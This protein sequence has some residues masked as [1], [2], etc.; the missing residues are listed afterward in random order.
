M[1][2][3]FRDLARQV[4]RSSS[5][6]V[7]APRERHHALETLEALNPRQTRELACAVSVLWDEFVSQIGGPAGW[8]A[9]TQ[10]E[11]NQYLGSLKKATQRVRLAGG[12]EKLHYALAPELVVLYVE[13][14]A[15]EQP[16]SQSAREIASAVSELVNRGGLIRRAGRGR[17]GSRP[18]VGTAA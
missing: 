6:P 15:K 16:S 5:A 18:H 9:S 11:Q 3:T 14:L 13:A 7:A 2:D 1:L 4:R 10:T 17:T 8:L 12:A